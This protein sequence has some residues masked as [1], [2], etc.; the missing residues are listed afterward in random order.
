MKK[1]KISEGVA[2][3]PP[4]GVQMITRLK[5]DQAPQVME[6]EAGRKPQVER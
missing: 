4:I 2:E 5:G 3:P 1:S 6:A